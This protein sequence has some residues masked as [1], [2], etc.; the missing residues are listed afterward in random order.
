ME[1]RLRIK[2]WTSQIYG[3]KH[4]TLVPPSYVPEPGEEGIEEAL[5]G[6]EL[7]ISVPAKYVKSATKIGDSGT[8]GR[9]SKEG[10]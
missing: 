5:E 9:P 8:T 10:E 7:G 6:L 1:G 3:T 4:I 2:R